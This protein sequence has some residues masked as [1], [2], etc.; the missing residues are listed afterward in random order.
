MILAAGAVQAEELTGTLKKINDNDI[1]CWS[2]ESFVP[3]SYY[4]NQQ[5][6]GRIL[7]T[8]PT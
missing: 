8:I 3:F 6:S 1:Y 2:S 5:K 4:D 7:S